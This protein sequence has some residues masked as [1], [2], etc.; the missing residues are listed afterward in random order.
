MVLGKTGYLYA[1]EG[2]WTPM[3]Y[4]TQKSDKG[5]EQTFFQE[6]NLKWIKYLNIRPET[7][8]LI[9]ENIGGKPH[10]IGVGNDFMDMTP[11]TQAMKTKINK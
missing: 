6:G 5:P 3:L 2:N 8:E 10:G 1:K 9:E 7:V 11:R 4:H